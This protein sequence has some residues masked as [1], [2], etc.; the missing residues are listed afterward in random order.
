MPN[1]MAMHSVSV[2]F[3]SLT[4]R[5]KLAEILVLGCIQLSARKHRWRYCLETVWGS[6]NT[7]FQKVL[8]NF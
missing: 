7:S 4:P 8:E 1:S 5:Q 2:E 6:D 3:N